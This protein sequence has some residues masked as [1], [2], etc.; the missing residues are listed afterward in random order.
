MNMVS[1]HGH[2][3]SKQAQIMVLPPPYFTNLMLVRR[4]DFT[5]Y[6]VLIIPPNQL[7]LCLTSSQIIYQ[8][9]FQIV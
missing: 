3:A 2:E 1:G 6:I 5:P 9:T 7:N 8:V 4:A